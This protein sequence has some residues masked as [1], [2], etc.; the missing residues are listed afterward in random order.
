MRESL[1]LLIG[2]L[3]LVVAVPRPALGTDDPPMGGYG[4]PVQT[5]PTMAN[6]PGQNGAYFKTKVAVINPTE[7]AFPITATL[8]G[9]EGE[10]GKRTIEVLPAQQLTWDNFLAEVFEYQGA[11][12]VRF[13]SVVD[14]NI[15][16]VFIVLA[17]V[18]TE[19]PHGR[20]KTV[21]STGGG[22]ASA[23]GQ[24]DS[25]G[26]GVTVTAAART[27]LGFFNAGTEDVE[28]ASQVR[29]GKGALL[30]TVRTTARAKAWTQVPIT[31]PVENGYVQWR[32]P[33]GSSVF[34]WIV[35]VDN[36]SNDGTYVSSTN[37]KVLCGV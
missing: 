31:T 32:F 3:A 13:S 27:N 22:N 12:A 25:Y 9:P 5:V 28:V 11:G 1:A 20:Y 16:N 8:Y 23:S 29:D 19:S 17:E 15:D 14:F 10:V 24:C 7:K 26:I 6:T 30:D 21:V 33:Q 18:Y 4:A 35:V 37:K 34:A 36:T 2:V